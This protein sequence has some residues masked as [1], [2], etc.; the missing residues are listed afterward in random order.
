MRY[1]GLTILGIAVVDAVFCI[2]LTI[3]FHLTH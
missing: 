1:V 2:A 3:A